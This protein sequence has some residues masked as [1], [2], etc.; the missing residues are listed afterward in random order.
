[1]RAEP[2]RSR[3]VDDER[4]AASIVAPSGSL[5]DALRA[6][7]DAGI[8]VCMVCAPDRRFAGLLTD[9]DVRRAILTGKG[10]DDAL[11][12]H[13]VSS[14]LCATPEDL[15]DNILD[16]M[17][18][19]RIDVV[20]IVDAEGRLVGAHTL[21]ELIGPDPL[22]NLA[23]IMAGGKGTRLGA[24]TKSVPKPM[25]DVAGR[26]I[27]ERI[28]QKLVGQGI[29]NI[30]ISVNYLAEVIVEHF[31]D[32]REFDCRITYLHESNDQPL[33]T[34]GSL[35]LLG[36]AGL[37]PNGPI[38]VL[39][40][41]VLTDAPLAEVIAFHMSR[42]SDVTVCTTEYDHTI[43]FGVVEDALDDRIVRIVE[44]PTEVWRVNAGI[45]AISPDALVHVKP[46]VEFPIVDLVAEVLSG[47]GR[48]VSYDLGSRWLDIGRPSELRRARGQD[49]VDE[50]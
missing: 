14:P 17:Q 30:A 13:V 32:G 38:L 39:N 1:M 36:D 34:G 24:L 21:Q 27:L 18:A 2:S 45:Y 9:G 35:A 10:P 25:L 15:R 29:R 33:G 22:D 20:P 5:R 19:R 48:V 28:V 23:V 41:D 50:R 37:E 47:G 44:K 6:I 12:D 3:Y 49:L 40:G 31:G 11:L 43:P 16:A 8:G 42:D 4:L 7:D 46:G 26:P